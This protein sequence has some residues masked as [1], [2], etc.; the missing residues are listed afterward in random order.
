MMQNAARALCAVSLL[1]L[2]APLRVMA[3]DLSDEELLN[4]FLMQRD[5]FRAAASSANGQT[6]GLTLVTLEN[7]DVVTETATL[8]APGT[9][10]ANDTA[11][12]AD[13]N[14]AVAG[15][16]AAPDAPEG[17]ALAVATDAPAAPA[18][19]ALAPDALAPD[20][21]AP[22]TAAGTVVAAVPDEITP[23]LVVGDL[24]PELQVNVRIEFDF[25]S[26]AL[27]PAQKP[28]LAQLCN[29]MKAADI[30]LFR[31]VGHTDASGSDDYNQNLSLLRAEEVQ[32]Y[33]ITECGIDAKR[34]QAVGLGERFIP[35]G[36][37][38][39][40]PEN[41]RVEFQALA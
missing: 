10:D 41:R 31:I 40:A 27:T 17:D 38:P 19:D 35:D 18:P 26:A 7:V 34:L 4:L 21:L 3:Q 32:R 16:P 14:V 11:T 39:K 22:D 8:G 20:A 23:T 12:A 29:V 37:D 13:T 24:A 33:F 1:A 6:R 15:A 30:Q 9:A 2:F 5:A 28:K 36:T 25:D